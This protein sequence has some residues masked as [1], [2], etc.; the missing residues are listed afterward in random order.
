MHISSHAIA[1]S[2]MFGT[3]I[4]FDTSS[5]TINSTYTTN[6]NDVTVTT[7]AIAANEQDLALGKG[8]RI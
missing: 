2:L 4:T 7:S 3:N 8:Y 1:V 5:S 6:K